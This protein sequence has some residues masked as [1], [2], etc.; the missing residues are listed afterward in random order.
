MATNNDSFP[1]VGLGEI[2]WDMLPCGKRLG[3]APANFAYHAHCLGGVGIVAS[4]IG[5]DEQGRQILEKLD[6]LDLNRNHIAVDKQ[7]PTGA[8]SV[9]VDEA[10]KPS[11]IIRENVAWDFI[12]VSPQLMEL[13][14]K[15]GAVCFGSLAQRSEVSRGTIQAFIKATRPSCLRIFDI[16]LRQSFYSPEIIEASLQLANVLKLNDEE[17]PIV[18]DMLATAGDEAAV[19]S[20]LAKR[21]NLRLIALSRGDKGSLFLSKGQTSSHNGCPVVVADTV[22]AGDAFTAALAMGMLRNHTLDRI[23][24]HANCVASFVC[25]QAGATPELPDEL[26]L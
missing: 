22:G 25:S 5:D 4:C 10:G 19:L 7:H 14:K 18:A 24:D 11:Y 17:L 9:E 16:N 3:G 20:K 1:L 21:Y 13:A 12:P 23:N 15:A 26:R 6:G 2:L 8:A